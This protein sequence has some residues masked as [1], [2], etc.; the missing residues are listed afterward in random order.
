MSNTA[1][2]SS[3]QEPSYTETDSFE[4]EVEENSQQLIKKLQWLIDRERSGNKNLS[5]LYYKEKIS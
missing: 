5:W 4:S 3:E 1:C 2:V